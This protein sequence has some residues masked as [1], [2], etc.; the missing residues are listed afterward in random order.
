MSPSLTINVIIPISPARDSGGGVMCKFTEIVLFGSTKAIEEIFVIFHPDG[1]TGIRI[2]STI[3]LPSFL[4]S[5]VIFE[6]ALETSRLDS[7][8][9]RDHPLV[10]RVVIMR[11]I[12]AKL[13]SSEIKLKLK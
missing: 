1:T 11:L 3:V 12:S 13:F 6:P 9:L 4:I 7:V 5:I 10:L 8:S 2:G